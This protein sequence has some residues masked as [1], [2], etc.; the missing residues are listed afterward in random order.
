MKRPRR[1]V[2]HIELEDLS[3]D[4]NVTQQG[5][6]KGF[7]CF[8]IDRGRAAYDPKDRDELIGC[9]V[10]GVEITMLIFSGSKVNVLS[11]KDWDHLLN[12]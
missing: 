8:R 10:G 3:D 7:D 2:N 9:S 1:A 4:V 12:K 6:I 5:C 11:G